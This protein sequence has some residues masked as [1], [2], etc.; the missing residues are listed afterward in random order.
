MSDVCQSFLLGTSFDSIVCVSF[1]NI[2]KI[3]TLDTNNIMI[4]GG[5]MTT[6]TK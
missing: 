1:K 6:N 5:S 4:I 3:V 2:H